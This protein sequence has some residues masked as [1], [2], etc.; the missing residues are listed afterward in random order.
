MWSGC[1]IPGPKDRWGRPFVVVWHPLVQEHR[2]VRLGERIRKSR[3]S[4]V[5]CDERSQIALA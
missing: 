3:H 5:A 1:G 2:Q 4:A